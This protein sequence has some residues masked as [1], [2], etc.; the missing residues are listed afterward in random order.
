[1]SRNLKVLITLFSMTALYGVYYWGIP[2]IVDLP[3]NI[4]LIE[5][6]VLKKSGYKIS[7]QNP[8]LKM[9]LIPAIKI[10]ADDF[11]ILNDDNSKAFDVE[12][13]YISIRLL[14]LIFKEI[15]IHDFSAENIQTNLVFDKDNKL[16]LGQYVIELPKE[17]AT[18]KL[19]HAR[20]HL[21]S[22]EI[23]LNDKVQTKKISMNGQYLTID[24]F[25]NNK[26]INFSTIAE[27]QT[28]KKKAFIKSDIDL[29][30]PIN[31]ISND[32]CDISGHIANLDLSDFSIYAKALSKNKIKALSGI[33]NFTA[34]TTETLDNHKKIQTNLYIK[35]LGIFGEDNAKSIHHV[36]KIALKSNIT[37]IK[38]GLQINDASV[39]APNISAFTTGE[40]TKLNNKI[41]NLNLKVT[42]NNSKAEDIIPLLPG[43]PD[44]C[45][46]MNL[47]LLKQTVFKGDVIGNL[48][49]KGKATTPDVRGNVMVSNAYMVQPIPNTE[50]ATIKLAFLG[51]KLNLDV[52][53]PTSPT[54]TVWVKGPIN[55][56]TKYSELMITSTDSVDLK[57]AQIVLNPLHKIL[58]FELGPVPIM[59]IKGKGGINLKIIGT[60]ENPHGWGQFYFRD[61]I[62]SFLDIHNMT[63]NNA[64]GTLDFDNQN[65]LFQSKT[66][67]LNGKPISVK[68]TCSLLGV[69]NFNV[70]ANGQDI[71]KLLNTIKT[72]PMLAD[73]QKLTT[74]ID[75]VRGN[76]NA[77][78]NLTGKVKDPHDIIFN[79]NLFAKG[80]IEL[81]SDTIK[82]KNAPIAI[83][84]TSGTI[85]FNNMDANFDLKTKL[86][87]SQIKVNGKIKDNNC[88]AQVVSHSFNLGDAVKTLPN[89]I[90]LPYKHDLATIN[91]SFVGKYKGDV[92]NIDYDNIYLK[93]NIYSN[94]GAKSAIIINDNSSFELKNSNFKL[95]KLQGTFKKSPYF[96]SLNINKNV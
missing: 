60:K 17:K 13:P 84:Q 29:K 46:D 70:V 38:N 83:S 9:G 43:E 30:L 34:Q 16:K 32:Q 1:M 31:K 75:Y 42:I 24:N 35:D 57:T 51:D 22:Y 71:G 86:N 92:E 12:K 28:G 33:I 39:S 93:G 52:K 87:K 15:D 11:A 45:P 65:T 89:N 48:E 63:I 8:S 90:K 2:A 55:L 66:A 80:S 14:P 23:N 47:Y 95:H 41:P 59:D 73:I 53:V 82:L 94:K 58:H 61:A 76:A 49:I 88:D 67:N 18:L 26:H 21:N 77:S 68:G 96:I 50:K 36:G 10:K 56:Y 81:L 4:D 27:I 7:I 54:Q 69:L 72:S 3:N 85:Q 25:E 62:V 37:T 19:S 5:Q 79:K 20:I 44:L 74:P 40:I 78:I 64:S 6:A 91:T